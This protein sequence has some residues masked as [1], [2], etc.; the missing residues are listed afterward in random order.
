MK[1]N[2]LF[3]IFFFCLIKGFAQVAISPTNALPNG[4]AMLD[5]SS[6]NKGLL[7][8]RLGTTQRI[9]ILSPAKGLMVY[10]TTTASFWLYNG[11]LWDELQNVSANTW[12]KNSTNIYNSNTGYVAIGRNNPFAKLDVFD[13]L[14][15]PVAVFTGGDN[16]WL[17]LSEKNINRGYI[18]SYAGN[19]EDVDFGTYGSNATGKVHL[20]TV[21]V[22]R[23]TVAAAGNIGIGTTTPTQLLEVNGAIKISD[24]N[25]TPSAG[26][27]RYNPAN[28]DFEGF[29]GTIWKSLTANNNS[30]APTEFQN[31]DVNSH[32]TDNLGFA[33]KIW[34]DYVFVGVPNYNVGASVNQ[35]AVKIFHKSILTNQYELFQT[36]T[37]SDGA[38]GD[39]FG[40]SLDAT[41]SATMCATTQFHFEDVYLVVGAPNKNLNTGSIYLYRYDYDTDQFIT[42]VNNFFASD[43]TPNDNYGYAVSILQGSQ[44]S[45]PTQVLVGAPLKTVSGNFAQGRAYVVNMVGNF[46]NPCTSSIITGFSENVILNMK[47]NA[48]N[49]YFGSAVAI[50]YKATSGSDEIMAAVGASFRSV[51]ANVNQ[52]IVYMFR[53]GLFMNADWYDSIA[54]AND[55]NTK[56]YFGNAISFANDRSGLVAIAAYNKENGANASQGAV[57]LFK[58]SVS[59]VGK[60]SWV[61][62]NKFTAP[63]G[64]ANDHFGSSIEWWGDNLM[65]GSSNRDDGAL[66]AGAIYLYQRIPYQDT[67]IRYKK[68]ITDIF[69]QAGAMLGKRISLSATKYVF[70]VPDWDVPGKV[71]AGKIIIGDIF[72]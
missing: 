41:S 47:T 63:D 25:A 62:K 60:R 49:S 4:S 43:G 3:C 8:P 30:A 10:D 66:D 56:D 64:N 38:A 13:T 15:S 70:G 5:I 72:Y 16:M 71:D 14:H 12:A 1:K 29:D 28:K 21:D 45:G 61:Q 59:S 9:S 54:V 22:P 7:I 19:P 18:G 36:L 39:K 44:L 40:Y 33:V 68:K 24:A 11:S 37:A 69:P 46:L 67:G 48:A 17:T 31:T 53:Y 52:G 35:G 34:G 26:T 6:N 55:G 65:V 20:T 57:Y 58:D 32:T 2:V 50:A 42:V 27:I 51:N 23:L